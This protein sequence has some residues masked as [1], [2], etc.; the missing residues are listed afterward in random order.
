MNIVL[1]DVINEFVEMFKPEC[2]FKKPFKLVIENNVLDYMKNDDEEYYKR[3]E[4]WTAG[5]YGMLYE[6]SKGEDVLII[7]KNQDLVNLKVTT[8]HEFVHLCD[9][10]KYGEL[11][12]YDSL[13][14]L[15]EDDTFRYWT[16]FH[17]PYMAYKYYI[18]TT[19]NLN[20]QMEAINLIRHLQDKL[21]CK[22]YSYTN[23][24]IYQSVHT[25]GEYI[26]LY[27]SYPDKINAHPINFYVNDKFKDIYEFLFTHTTIDE[28]LKDYQRFEKLI[29]SI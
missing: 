25:Y 15:Q 8:I 13:R 9:Y 1:I 4:E 12:P 19:P 11:H 26:A 27:D 17:A 24:A 10:R 21:L 22:K 29:N 6:N 16:E 7:S 14:K 5:A 2:C 20:A 23:C 3:E 18:A 28:F